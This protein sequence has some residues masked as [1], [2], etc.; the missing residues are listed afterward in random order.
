[1]T[2]IETVYWHD[3]MLAQYIL[4]PLS[5]CRSQAGV[6]SKWLYRLSWF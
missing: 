2:G 4:Q 1:M 6:L 3:A 5:V